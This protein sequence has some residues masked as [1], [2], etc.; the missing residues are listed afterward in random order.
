M[1]PGERERD[2]RTRL[3]G[4]F[5]SLLLRFQAATWFL[6][7]EGLEAFDRDL[8]EG[9]PL[10]L[11][12]WHGRY[13]PLFAL[14]RGR[15]AMVFSSLSRRGRVIAEICRHCGYRCT[16]LADHGR[17]DSLERMRQALAGGL[18]GGLAVD[19]PL[20][21]RHAVKRGTIVLASE[22]RR[23]IYPASVDAARKKVLE[24]RWD[25]MEVPRLLTRVALVIG[26]PLEVPRNL[27]AE[28]EERWQDRLH[29]ALDEVDLRAAEL[30]RRR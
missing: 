21:P 29:Q 23:I 26:E 25:K 1:S 4:A 20:G 17:E 15:D 3:L 30:V 6:R 11:A 10:L 19:G 27:S 9:R 12:F 16:L 14:L 5:W 2:L 28:D 18:A 24:E 13:L 7:T 8:R 22:Q